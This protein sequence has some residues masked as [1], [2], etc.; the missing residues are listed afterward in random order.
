MR[1]L[2]GREPSPEL[3]Q[4]VCARYEEIG[5]SSPLLAIAQELARGVSAALSQL[6]SPMP[7]EVGMR[8]WKPFVAGAVDALVA[9]G[10]DHIVMVS[11]SPYEAEVTHSEY[12]AALDAALEQHPGVSSAEAPLLSAVPAFVELQTES[13]RTAIEELG[14]PSAPVVFSAH[15]LPLSDIARDPAYIHGLEAAAADV[16]A[17]LGLAA[18]SPSEVL[19][20]I[21]AYGASDDGGTWLVAY[22]SKG[23]RGGEWLGPDVDEV[24]SAAAEGSMRGIVVVPLGFATDHM[25]TRYD[26]DVV[27]RRAAEQAGLA[28]VRSQLPNAHPAMA[29]GIAHAVLDTVAARS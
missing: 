4:R 28:F 27:S 3:V 26:L 29:E 21:E 18:G 6:G 8:Y 14:I 5:G 12:R 2:M 13:A 16:A 24:I 9:Q 1:S 25:E 22:Q 23:A 15:S 19:P 10:V 20:G 7:V 11:L 17:R